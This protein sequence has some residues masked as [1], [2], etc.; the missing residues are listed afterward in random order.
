MMRGD[1]NAAP[2]LPLSGDEER[3]VIAGLLSDRGA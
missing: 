1:P 2:R 3:S